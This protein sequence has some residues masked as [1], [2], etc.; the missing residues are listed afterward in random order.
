MTEKKK[1]S[2]IAKEVEDGE[3]QQRLQLV[4]N[5][6]KA[7]G[8]MVYHMRE[9]L[10]VADIECKTQ[11]SDLVTR[12]DRACD[13]M[14]KQA[15]ADRFKNDAILTEETGLVW[16]ENLNMCREY[17]WNDICALES[18]WIADPIDGTTNYIHRLENYAVCLA[19]MH[20]G[21]VM[22]SGMY[23][24]VLNELLLS[25][26]G[27]GTSCNGKPVH[28]SSCKELKNALLGTGFGYSGHRERLNHLKE[29]ASIADEARGI[30][31]LGSA[32]CC[33][34]KV[35]QGRLD[36]FWIR[37]CKPWDIASGV[38]MIQ[39]AG[40]EIQPMDKGTCFFETGSV[41]TANKDLL[42]KM[43]TCLHLC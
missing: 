30:R 7:C 31:H 15:I 29:I 13:M 24:P 28:V 17:T 11:A 41:I 3:L 9:E 39:E 25:A 33:L 20:F 42:V 37:D 16:A 12:A 4:D 23:M 22:V 34:A 5:T 38:L 32:A 8:Q 43:A 40:G 21:E 2:S 6:L 19:W 18:V 10:E 26:K 14:L 1:S 35:A 36:G 27:H